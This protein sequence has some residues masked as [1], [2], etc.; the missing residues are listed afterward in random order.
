[1]KKTVNFTVS[2]DDIALG[3]D[4][5]NTYECEVNADLQV[6]IKYGDETFYLNN[7]EVELNDEQI[8]RL[9]DRIVEVALELAGDEISSFRQAEYNK[10]IGLNWN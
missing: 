5:E 4:F 6:E 3:V 1:M 9:E 10:E 2:D 7:E 8:G